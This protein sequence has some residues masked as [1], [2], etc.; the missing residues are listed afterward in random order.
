[1]NPQNEVRTLSKFI[2][3]IERGKELHPGPF[4]RQLWKDALLSEI[5]EFMAEPCQKCDFEG[6]CFGCNGLDN[7]QLAKFR[8]EIMDIAVVA[9]RFGQM[10]DEIITEKER[11]I[12][13]NK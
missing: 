11:K 4:S 13:T 5:N 10:L 9:Y 7:G 12:D 1:M 8:A 3:S 6:G 2:Q